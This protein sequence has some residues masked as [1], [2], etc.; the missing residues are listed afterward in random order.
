[1]ISNPKDEFC[2]VC[3]RAIEQMVRHYAGQ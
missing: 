3:Q 2:P 1:M